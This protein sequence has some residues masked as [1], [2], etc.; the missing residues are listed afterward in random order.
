MHVPDSGNTTG[1]STVGDRPDP[2]VGVTPD[3]SATVFA[4]VAVHPARSVDYL[5]HGI[6]A[7]TGYDRT[8]LE[9]DPRRL[10]QLVRPADRRRLAAYLRNR[11][12]WRE[13]I[14]LQITRA[15][16]STRPIEA[17]LA[18]QLDPESVPISIDIAA[19]R[20]DDSGE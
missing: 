7:L 1:G 16:G 4:H 15:D 13:R 12:R 9:H 5:S 2:V 19:R 11:S 18:P 8:T 3:A 17:W 14:E 20:I 10:L 6:E